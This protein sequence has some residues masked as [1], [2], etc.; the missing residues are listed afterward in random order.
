VHL[1]VKQRRY[2]LEHSREH[3]ATTGAA[4]ESQIIVGESAPEAAE[5]DTFPQE[6]YREV[7]AVRSYQYIHSGN[8]VYL[9]EPGSR[10]VIERIDEDND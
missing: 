8:D 7:P 6:V 3:R 5:I 9:V 2:L 1:S 10:R 4:H